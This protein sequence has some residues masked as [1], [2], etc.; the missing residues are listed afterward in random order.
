LF[1]KTNIF[2]KLCDSKLY[3]KEGIPMDPEINKLD[4]SIRV[5]EERLSLKKEQLEDIR[6]KCNHVWGKNKGV[7]EEG[8][9]LFE[10]KSCEICGVVK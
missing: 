9:V 7:G 2:R 6:R 1:F 3:S 8:E 10:Y 4:L 5:L